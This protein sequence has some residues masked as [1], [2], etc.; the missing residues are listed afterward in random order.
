[1]RADVTRHVIQI[2]LQLERTENKFIFML[3][4]SYLDIEIFSWAFCF[5]KKHSV[6][7]TAFQ[8]SR[9]AFAL[10]YACMLQLCYS[11]LTVDAMHFYSHRRYQFT[12]C[13]LSLSLWAAFA[14]NVT[15]YIEHRSMFIRIFI[16]FCLWSFN[17]I[18]YTLFTTFYCF[19]FI[20]LHYWLIF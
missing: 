11:V 7:A 20:Y 3:F 1:M 2:P 10:I 12:V 16:P 8:P 4:F 13:L 14:S 18:N 17:C 5:S 19:C 9:I 15:L 6:D